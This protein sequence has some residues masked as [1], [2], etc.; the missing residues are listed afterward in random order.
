MVK[1]KIFFLL[2]KVFLFI[3][4][5][6]PLSIGVPGEL[7]GY[8][9]AYKKFGKLPWKSLIEPSIKLCENGYIL[10]NHQYN[11]L[12]RNARIKNDTNLK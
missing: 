8:W 7:K 1:R 9:E 2:S 12:Y 10:N 4:Y 3:S 6:G 5:L 11:A